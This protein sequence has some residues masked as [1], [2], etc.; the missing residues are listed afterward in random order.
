MKIGPKYKIARRLGASL[1]PKTQTPK[2][3]ISAAKKSVRVFKGRGRGR[4]QSE[5]NQQLIE[6]QKV[7]FTYGLTERQL[8]NYV[9]R[10]HLGQLLE[11]RLDNVI[12]R[13]GVASSRLAARQ[14]V[15]HGHVIV[16]GAR[17]TIPS[18]QL[19]VGDRIAVRPQSQQSAL[20]NNLSEK[21]KDYVVPAW[22]EFEVEKLEGQ[23]KTLPLETD[24]DPGL[25]F[26][27]VTEFYSRV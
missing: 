23:V 4:G 12:F 27:A 6:K 18:Y 22:L 13:L 11:A 14:M 26:A 21:L 25:N 10:G 20:F 15:A 1:F 2:F 17:V 16:N 9:K 3:A 8:A 7:R 24:M 5:Y 19:K